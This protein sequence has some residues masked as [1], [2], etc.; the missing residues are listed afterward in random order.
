VNWLLVS[1]AIGDTSVRKIGK[2]RFI[3]QA[4]SIV[5]SLVI[6]F[7]IVV[8]TLARGLKVAGSSPIADRVI[9]LIPN[10]TH[11]CSDQGIRY[12]YGVDKLVTTSTLKLYGLA[13][14]TG[15]FQKYHKQWR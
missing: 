13:S 15:S 1:H 7:G 3:T 14:N 10:F 2:V 11:N 4:T 9:S 8:G 5:L 12:P 6:R